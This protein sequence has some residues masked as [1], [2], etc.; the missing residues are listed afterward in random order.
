MGRNFEFG[1]WMITAKIVPKN[2]CY[3]NRVQKTI[4]ELPFASVSKGFLLQTIFFAKQIWFVWKPTYRWNHREQMNPIWPYL[5]FTICCWFKRPQI[6]EHGLTVYM[7]WWN[8]IR[9]TKGAY[10]PVLVVTVGY[11]LW[12]WIVK[13]QGMKAIFSHFVSRINHYNLNKNV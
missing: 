10:R 12:W 6:T 11:Q 7:R 3:Y 8:P 1:E 4:S 2:I 9:K 5:Y 13:R